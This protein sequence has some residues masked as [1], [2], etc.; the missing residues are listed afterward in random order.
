VLAIG[1]ALLLLTDV[2]D[3]GEG[4]PAPG[5]K[6]A[7][8]RVVSVTDGDT[9]RVDIGG[10]EE[11]VRYIGIDTPESVIPDEPPECFG[12]EA[13]RANR[14]LV[15]GRSVRLVFGPERRDQYDRL[16]AYVYAGETFVNAELVRRGFARTLEIAPNTGFADEFARLQQ[17]A[18]N[19]GRGLWRAC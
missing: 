11:P 18:A 14:D 19:A 13:A 3:D 12:E 2:G 16:L 15:E 1:I 17:A 4:A 8:A 10:R 9:I 5:G 7:S 6:R